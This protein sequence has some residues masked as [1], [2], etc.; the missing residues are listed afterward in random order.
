MIYTTEFSLRT[1][2]LNTRFLYIIY[3]WIV[4][5][6][7]VLAC[8]QNI[9]FSD[10]IDLR[11]SFNKIKFFI[12]LFVDLTF[13]F[14]CLLD[15]CW[16]SG[17]KICKCKFWITFYAGGT[18][19]YSFKRKIDENAKLWWHVL[20]LDKNIFSSLCLKRIELKC[21]CACVH[22]NRKYFFYMKKT[23]TLF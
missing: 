16:V 15:A 10:V 3:H 14:D 18:F 8:I 20:F 9:L 2:I 17:C 19:Y 1:Y 4:L 22:F 23:E 21:V 11:N 13:D 5:N 6:D 7:V 12:V